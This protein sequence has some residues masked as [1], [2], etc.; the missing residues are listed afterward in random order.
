MKLQAAFKLSVLATAVAVTSTTFAATGN[1]DSIASDS[2]NWNDVANSNN[3]VTK[4][5][6]QYQFVDL[7]STTTLK[8]QPLPGDGKLVTQLFV[9]GAK[10]DADGK[11]TNLNELDKNKGVL[12][13]GLGADAKYYEVTVDS[14]PTGVNKGKD[15][16]FEITVATGD[17]GSSTKP[18]LA[19]G[20]PIQGGLSQYTVT[21]DT[22][23][24]DVRV[25]DGNFL[26]YGKKE[27]IKTVET[28]KAGNLTDDVKNG[29]SL[30]SNLKDDIT[31][32]TDPV[33]VKDQTITVGNV[34]TDK[35][36]APGTGL[37][38]DAVHG[39]QIKD[40]QNDPKTGK[41]TVNKTATLQAY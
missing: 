6:T 38:N 18:A 36:N 35:K 33:L 14:K 2:S 26:Q 23:T 11:V 34:Y 13:V 22:T 4:D 37:H 7:N 40:L 3:S 29:P 31:K 24:Q 30:T 5:Q 16:H 17:E 21:Q 10:I 39:L 9:E 1:K 15:G 41:N 25:V 8:Q 32:S 27:E 28:T 19:A 20:K 12:Q